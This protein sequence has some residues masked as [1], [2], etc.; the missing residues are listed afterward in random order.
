L[1]VQSK[2][3]NAISE[4]AK[5]TINKKLQQLLPCDFLIK[6]KGNGLNLYVPDY[7]K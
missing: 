3:K 5:E 7:Y 1:K 6:V 2:G 4:Y